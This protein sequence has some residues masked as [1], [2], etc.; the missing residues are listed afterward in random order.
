[1]RLIILFVFIVFIFGCK[2]EEQLEKHNS[3]LVTKHQIGLINDSTQ[4]KDL[5]AIFSNDSLISIKEDDSFIGGINPI[6]LYTKTGTPLLQVFPNDAHDSTATINYVHIQNPAYQTDRNISIKSYFI[7]I[8]STY[9]ISEIKNGMDYIEVYIDSLK[10]I[11][12][13]RKLKLLRDFDFGTKVNRDQ[14]PDS[15]SIDFFIKYF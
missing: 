3:Y 15:I 8:K 14:I 13:F 9:N 11:F 10:S 5:K 7:D 12:A 6:R 1:M 4:V 2:S